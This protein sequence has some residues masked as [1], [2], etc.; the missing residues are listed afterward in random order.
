MLHPGRLFSL[1]SVYGMQSFSGNWRINS[2]YHKYFFLF[3]KS[4]QSPCHEAPL[5]DDSMFVP[6]PVPT[7]LNLCTSFRF[8]HPVHHP[9]AVN[10]SQGSVHGLCALWCCIPLHCQCLW[11]PPRFSGRR[12]E[13]SLAGPCRSVPQAFWGNCIALWMTLDFFLF[14]SLP[15]SCSSWTVGSLNLE[16][17]RIGEWVVSWSPVE[18]AHHLHTDLQVQIPGLSRRKVKETRKLHSHRLPA[19]L[20]PFRSALV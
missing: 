11:I 10:H 7:V 8:L 4:N 9:M 15:L 3:A 19:G 16:G 12:T 5:P 18:S 20:S 2:C 14:L 17:G 1:P 6:F 13:S